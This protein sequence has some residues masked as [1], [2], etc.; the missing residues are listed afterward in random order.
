MPSDARARGAYYTRLNIARYL[1]RWAIR[2]ATDT[3]LEP[4]FGNGAFI[5]AAL[6]RL[7]ELGGSKQNL[8]AVEVHQETYQNFL[9]NQSINPENFVNADFLSV[10][11]CFPID[12]VIGNPPYVRLRHLDISSARL[13]IARTEAAGVKMTRDGSLWMPFTVHACSFL[14]P[15]GRLA[16][17][18][19]FEITHVKYAIPLWE[20]FSRSFEHI[21][22]IR[23]HEDLFPGI[24]EET[25]LLLA[26]NYTKTTDFVQHRVYLTHHDLLNNVPYRLAAIPLE[27]IYHRQKPFVKSLLEP[28]LRHLLS[29]LACYGTTVP[30][31]AICKFKI[32]YV[33]GDKH[34]FHPDRD[35]K[36]KYGLPPSNLINTVKNSRQLRGRGLFL[37]DPVSETSLYYPVAITAED[38]SYIKFGEKTGINNRYK[39]KARHPWYLTP[40]I[41]IP[42][43]ILTVFSETPILVLNSAGFA[44]SNSLLCGFLKDPAT[45]PED[46]ACRWYNSLVLL[47]IELNIHSLGGGVLVLIPGEV[48]NLLFP[49]ISPGKGKHAFLKKIDS[50]LKAEQTAKAYQAGDQFLLQNCLGLTPGQIELIKNGIAT[51]QHWRKPHNKRKKK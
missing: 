32:G 39:C 6:E 45:N 43:V 48:N 50:C 41:E 42:D 25:V 19:P 40:G 4:S 49:A 31:Q 30:L 11:S 18:L 16:L 34:F 20:F 12:T 51:L 24:E 23:T 7:E 2:K 14:K 22:V 1:A 5:D 3:V 9:S 21:T 17:V 47:S 46:F 13:A 29:D 35:I 8:F 37:S 44:A 26:E 33:T 10:E 28:D 38:R 27:T 36:K 15:G